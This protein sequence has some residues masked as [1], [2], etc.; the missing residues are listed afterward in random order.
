M[1][2]GTTAVA[3]MRENRYFIG[4]EIDKGYY[5]KSL[6][7]IEEEEQLIDHWTSNIKH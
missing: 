5:E 6:K 4:F 1:G 7:R 3:A 2:S